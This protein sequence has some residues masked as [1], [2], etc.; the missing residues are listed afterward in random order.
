[1]VQSAQTRVQAIGFTQEAVAEISSALR[2]LLADIFTLYLKTKNFHWRMTGRHF[3]DYQLLLDEHA[4]QILTMTDEIAERARKLGGPTLR[5]VGD[6]ARLQRLKDNDA[7]HVTPRD[8]LIELRGDNLQLT[9]FLRSTHKT[10]GEHGDLATTSL[11]ET[12]IHQTEYRSW[13]LAAI[14]GEI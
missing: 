14:A 12:W 6:I 8:M 2:Q 10:C 5:S 4:G 7:D 9:E 11:I 3:R 13:F 1:M